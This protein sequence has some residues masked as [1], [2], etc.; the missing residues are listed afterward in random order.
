[1]TAAEISGPI[2]SPGI[3]VTVFTCRDRETQLRQLEQIT[4]QPRSRSLLS[5][6]TFPVIYKWIFWELWSEKHL[7]DCI[8]GRQRWSYSP[9]LKRRLKP[10]LVFWPPPPLPGSAGRDDVK[11]NSTQNTPKQLKNNLIVMVSLCQ[12]FENTCFWCVKQNCKESLWLFAAEAWNTP[13]NS[14]YNI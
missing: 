6:K 10:E 14:Y 4:V 3:M 11:V 13:N 9:L 5:C 1:M 7:F 2:P 8:P 12:L